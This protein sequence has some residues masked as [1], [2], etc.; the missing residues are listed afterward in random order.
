MGEH[1]LDAHPNSAEAIN[2][3]QQLPLHCCC[4]MVPPPVETVRA[5]L[6]VYPAAAAHQDAKGML[7]LHTFAQ[8]QELAQQRLAR[9]PETPAQKC[10]PGDSSAAAE[11]ATTVLELLLDAYPD[12]TK[13]VDRSG[14]LPLHRACQRAAPLPRV[15]ELLIEADPSTCK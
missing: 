2:R 8:S 12:A 11:S 13:T 10:D 4:A 14:K 7:P 6:R 9:E 15:V 1:L 5:L 3:R